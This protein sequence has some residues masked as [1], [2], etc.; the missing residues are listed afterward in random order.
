METLASRI[1]PD[2]SFYAF[3]KW[4]YYPERVSCV[5][6]GDFR[7][8]KPVTVQLIPSQEAQVQ[9]EIASGL[10]TQPHREFI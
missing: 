6:Q 10:Y 3:G 1:H 9:A 5:A 8:V 7:A 4:L 2:Y